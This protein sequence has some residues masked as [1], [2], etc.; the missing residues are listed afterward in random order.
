MGFV[1]VYASDVAVLDRSGTFT[2]EIV[3]CTFHTSW[4]VPAALYRM[5]IFLTAHAMGHLPF[6]MWRFQVHYSVQEGADSAYV[7][8]VGVGSKVYLWLVV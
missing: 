3:C 2:S 6:G 4:C 8:I 5:S 1:T 7:L